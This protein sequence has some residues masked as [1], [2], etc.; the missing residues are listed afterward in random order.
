MADGIS[1]GV[2]APAILRPLATRLVADLGGS[3]EWVDE[4]DRPLYHA[5]LAHGANHL[6]TL[7]NE[8]LD[9][10]RDAGVIHPERVLGPLLR[11]ALENTLGHGDAALTGPV[12]GATPAPSPGTWRRCAGWRRTPYR[13]IWRWPG[14]PP[15]GRSPPAGCARWTPSRCSACWRRRRPLWAGR[16]GQRTVRWSRGGRRGGGVSGDGGVERVTSLERLTIC[17]NRAEL[18]QARSAMTGRVGVVMTMGALHEGHAALLRA[19]RDE[20][21]H[22]LATIFVNPLQFGPNEDFQRYPR[23]LED[24]LEILRE[25]GADA[26]FVPDVAEIYPD[27]EPQVRVAPGPLGDHPRGRASARA[28]RRRA[29][30]GAQAAQPDPRRHLAY[31]GEKDYQQLALIRSMVADLNVPDEIVG[32]PTV[33]EPDG[34]AL[35]SRNRYLSD[36][37]RDGRA[38]P[39]AG[40]AGRC[41]R[42]RV[43]ARVAVLAAAHAELGASPKR[44]ARLPRA[45]R[46][47]SAR[48]RRMARPGCWSPPGWAA[49]D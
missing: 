28:L 15:T 4:H 17:T 5:A 24:D 44:G 6:V 3:V 49:P 30:R 18:A 9:R 1:F 19:A 34:L 12:A 45:H 38:G 43:R 33:R 36:A 7:V 2:T 20:A 27:G 22:L 48:R 26:V 40:A 29:H 37:D 21:D 25:R 16:S 46:P 23:T 10:L 8:A 31:F 14:G 32:V 47:G 42:R 35:S 39:V 13:R 41:A 11:A